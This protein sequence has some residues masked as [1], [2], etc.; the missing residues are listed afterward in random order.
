MGMTMKQLLPPRQHPQLKL[1]LLQPPLL[2]RRSSSKNSSRSTFSCTGGCSAVL[3]ISV[4][5][6][7]CAYFFTFINPSTTRVYVLVKTKRLF[8]LF[9][10]PICLFL[11]HFF[12]CYISSLPPLS[13]NTVLTGGIFTFKPSQLMF[14]SFNQLPFLPPPLRFN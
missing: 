11:N 4:Y 10:F 1:R 6:S 7:D 8:R 2:P 13:V 5:M 3:I 12:L 9:P 14:S